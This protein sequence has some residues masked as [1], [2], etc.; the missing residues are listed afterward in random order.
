MMS[1]YY[2]WLDK[3]NPVG[4]GRRPW[5]SAVRGRL[6]KEHWLEDDAYQIQLLILSDSLCI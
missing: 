2:R 6:K 5:L 3:A 1:H 4:V